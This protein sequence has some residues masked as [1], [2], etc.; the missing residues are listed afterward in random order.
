MLTFV[1][2]FKKYIISQLEDYD[3]SDTRGSLLWLQASSN[4]WPGANR[5]HGAEI[6]LRQ[7]AG[8]SRYYISIGAGYHPAT[9]HTKTHDIQEVVEIIKNYNFGE[10]WCQ[11]TLQT[12]T[13][14]NNGKKK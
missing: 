5:E 3:F 10:Q 4:D 11:N 7:T 1:N 2:Q 8:K 14:W 12:G 6:K 9:Y 13:M